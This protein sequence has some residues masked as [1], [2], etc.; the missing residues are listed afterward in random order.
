MEKHDLLHEFPDYQDKIHELKMHDQHFKNLF[1]EYDELEHEIRR[2]NTG[3]EL[4]SDAVIHAKKAKLLHI[5]DA[6][7]AKLASFDTK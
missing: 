1:D 6:L 3:V 7:F 5:K 4:G 2:L